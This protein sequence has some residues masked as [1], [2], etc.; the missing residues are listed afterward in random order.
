M[1]ALHCM[2]AKDSDLK[3][4]RMIVRHGARGDIPNDKG[5]TAAEIMSRKRD[6]AFRTMG[7]RLARA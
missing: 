4:F 3:H 5:V 2:L 1:T 6:P 7:A